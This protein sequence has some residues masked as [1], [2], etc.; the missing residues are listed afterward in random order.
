MLKYWIPSKN[1]LN[2]DVNSLADFYGG[3]PPAAHVHFLSSDS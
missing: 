3:L 2:T 1:V